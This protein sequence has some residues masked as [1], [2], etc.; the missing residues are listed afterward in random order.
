MKGEM[1]AKPTNRHPKDLPP[2][3]PH[4]GLTPEPPPRGEDHVI[5]APA[6]PRLMPIDRTTAVRESLVV[7]PLE[8]VTSGR[9]FIEPV[10]SWFVDFYESRRGTARSKIAPPVVNALAW[11]DDE[12]LDCTLRAK[13]I[14]PGPKLPIGRRAKRVGPERG[15][16]ELNLLAL[17]AHNAASHLGTALFGADLGGKV[18]A[19]EC[20]VDAPRPSRAIG[21][22]RK[23]VLSAFGYAR[24]VGDTSYTEVIFLTPASRAPAVIA[25]RG[26]RKSDWIV[27]FR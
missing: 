24:V 3:V 14:E 2:A 7:V 12:S 10:R 15:Y 17:A 6:V 5:Y 19:V 20:T 11:V 18:D 23:I 1:I 4:D 13:E 8:F 27:I 21:A 22:G 26:R 9:E 16:I 25:E